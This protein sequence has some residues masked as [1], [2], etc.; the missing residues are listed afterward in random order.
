MG[1][2]TPPQGL[3]SRVDVEGGGVIVVREARAIDFGSNL[4]VVDDG[5]GTVTVSA[6]AAGLNAFDSGTVTAT[7]GS[8]PAVDTTITGVSMSETATHT[9]DVFVDADPG[10][11]AD[12]AFNWDYGFQWDESDGEVDILL[13]VNWDTDPGGGND[14]TLRWRLSEL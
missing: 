14:V 7:G 5:D 13:T 4:T 12:Y 2:R 8:T 1:G 11:N 3:D 9:F 6:P 10:F